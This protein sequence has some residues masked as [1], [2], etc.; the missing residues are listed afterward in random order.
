MKALTL[1]QAL[2]EREELFPMPENK[3]NEQVLI[4]RRRYVSLIKQMYKK[5]M[6]ILR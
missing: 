3:Y 5:G 6:V 2:Q 4:E 1:E